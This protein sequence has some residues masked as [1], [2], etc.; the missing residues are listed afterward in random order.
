MPSVGFGADLDV[1]AVSPQVTV[2]HPAGDRLPLL[3]TG[4][5]VTFSAA[6]HHRS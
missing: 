5:A 3:F 6:E 1:Q 4:P 2:S